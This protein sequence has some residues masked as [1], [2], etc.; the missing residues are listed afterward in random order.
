MN[1]R[2][3]DNRAILDEIRQLIEANPE[4]RFGQL[5]MNYGFLPPHEPGT[6]VGDR[7]YKSSTIFNEQSSVT[8]SR[9]VSTRKRIEAEQLAGDES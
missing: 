3:S 1:T 2:L 9:V 4:L 5:L 7:R 6:W 8:L